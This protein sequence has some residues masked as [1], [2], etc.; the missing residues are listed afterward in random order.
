[1][2]NLSPLRSD[3][4]RHHIGLIAASLA[5]VSIIFMT[6]AVTVTK[7]YAQNCPQPAING[8][9]PYPS[10]LVDSFDRAGLNR[11]SSSGPSQ[12]RLWSGYPINRNSTWNHRPY[13]PCILLKA[14]G[15]IES[16]GWFQFNVSTYGSTGP[17]FIS[18]D[19]GYGIMQITSGMDGSL[20]IFDPQ[21][22]AGEPAYNIGTG[23]LFLQR[24][25]NSII[26]DHDKNIG[27]ND[28]MVVENWYYAVWAYNGWSYFNNPNNPRYP[29]HEVHGVVDKVV[30]RVPIGLTKSL[31]GDVRLTLQHIKVVVKQCLFG[32]PCL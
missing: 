31:Y 18:S 6:Q 3:I 8:R 16:T 20:G 22:V 9:Q 23:A 2:L 21:R 32:M 26:Y 13:A 24:K 14:I 30:R 25:W 27:K 28:P 19:C 10:E 17:T 4:A 7:C 11:L 5:T 1:M 15:Y 12:A 29:W